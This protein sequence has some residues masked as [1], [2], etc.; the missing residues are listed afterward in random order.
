L[1]LQ[2]VIAWP[3]IE[4]VSMWTHFSWL[5]ITSIWWEHHHLLGISANR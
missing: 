3:W 5:L 1:I 2:G 4:R